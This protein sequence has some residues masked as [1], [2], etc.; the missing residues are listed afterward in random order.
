MLVA[1]IRHI[2]KIDGGIPNDLDRE[3]VQLRDRSRTGVQ[4]NVVLERAHLGRPGWQNQIL[5]LHGGENILG[6]KSFRLHQAGIQIDHDLALFA[7]VQERND[8]SRHGHQLRSQEILPE[9]IQLLLR[10]AASG[11]AQLQNGDARSAIVDDQGRQS[12][13]RQ[14]AEDGLGSG[15]Y[16]GIRG[17]QACTVLQVNLHDGLTIYGS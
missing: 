6:S 7:A 5:L 4:S 10:E 15:R 16:L 1:H 2:A 8:G 11:K 12:A 14:L 3:V 17:I 13:R 9:V